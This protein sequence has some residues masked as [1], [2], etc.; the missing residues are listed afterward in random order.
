[1]QSTDHRK[2]KKK[3]DQNVDAPTP[4]LK[5]KKIHRR[6]YGSKV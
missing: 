6:G 1:M 2:L 5:G 4:S 3:D